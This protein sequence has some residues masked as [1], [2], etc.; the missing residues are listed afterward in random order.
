MIAG[1]PRPLRRTHREQLFRFQTHALTDYLQ[2]WDDDACHGI[3]RHAEWVELL[4]PLCLNFRKLE[5]L[6]EDHAPQKSGQSR[7]GERHLEVLTCRVCNQSAGR[8]FESTAAIQRAALR[9]PHVDFC[10]VHHRSAEWARESSGLLVPVDYL[11][12]DLTDVKAAHQMAFATLGYSWILT[13]RLNELRCA[14]RDQR[15]SGDYVIA[16]AHD[17]DGLGAFAVYEALSPVPCVVVKA[18]RVRVCL[19]MRLSPPNLAAEF[20]RLE[21]GKG[22]D[23]FGVRRHQ[24]SMR[25]YPWPQTTIGPGHTPEKTWDHSHFFALDRCRENDHT[26]RARTPLSETTVFVA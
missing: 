21:E 16:D 10:D 20:K 12:F 11:S 7:L 24:W 23:V 15:Q 19:P 8:G 26:H 25:C 1:R 6:D 13:P 9:P 17:A 22:P 3:A 18:D 14:L 4:C 2:H 5:D